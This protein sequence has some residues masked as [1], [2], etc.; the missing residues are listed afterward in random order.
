MCFCF[1]LQLSCHFVGR[2]LTDIVGRMTIYRKH[3]APYFNFSIT[4]TVDRYFVEGIAK[5]Y[6]GTEKYNY[7]S[8]G[9][10]LRLKRSS[11]FSFR[12]T[13]RSETDIYGKK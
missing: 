2:H 7:T 10:L 11:H 12:V 9:R 8:V 6:L 5:V 1:L 3:C 4:L 13:L